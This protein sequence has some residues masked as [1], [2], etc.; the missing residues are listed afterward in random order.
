MSTAQMAPSGYPGAAPSRKALP[1]DRLQQPSPG[2]V[3]EGRFQATK[4]ISHGPGE[5]KQSPQSCNCSRPGV[6][7]SLKVL[8][9]FY[10]QRCLGDDGLKNIFKEPEI[11]PQELS[12]QATTAG[13]PS[14]FPSQ[15]N[16][17]E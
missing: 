16:G 5:T 2:W 13:H 8:D 10:G 15:S 11:W 1:P 17:T 12:E 14:C 4:H 3:T 7:V 6:N 9:L